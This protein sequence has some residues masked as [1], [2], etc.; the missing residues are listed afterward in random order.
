MILANVIY[1][2]DVLQRCWKIIT[3]KFVKKKSQWFLSIFSSFYKQGR[4]TEN[5]RIDCK[6]YELSY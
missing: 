5:N 3:T 4:F 2:S 1:E 6:H